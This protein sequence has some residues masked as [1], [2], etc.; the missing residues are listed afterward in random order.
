[1]AVMEAM[2][3]GLPIVASAIR[4][5]IDLIDPGKG[6]F[7][8]APD[9]A[10]GFADAIRAI[11]SDRESLER[12]KRYNLEKVRAYSIGAVTEQMA[13]LYKSVM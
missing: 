8:V 5:N 7:L 12:M 10:D 6:G 13:E 4:G 11:L 9:D 1:M 2:A 3:C